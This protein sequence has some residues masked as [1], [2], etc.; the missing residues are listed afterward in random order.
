MQ[1][2]I[3]FL[4]FAFL[5]FSVSFPRGY[6]FSQMFSQ[7]ICTSIIFL[8]FTV[9]SFLYFSSSEVDHCSDSPCKNN[10]TCE[11][12]PNGYICSCSEKFKGQNCEGFTCIPFYY[13]YF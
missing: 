13:I 2:Q 10:G 4:F 6:L 1:R 8:V 3:C 11:N 9:L 7:Y 5:F 12:L